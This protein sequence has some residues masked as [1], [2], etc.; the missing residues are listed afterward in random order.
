MANKIVNSQI[1]NLL[2]LQMYSRK[3]MTLAEN[4]FQ[5]KNLPK[6]INTAYMNKTLIN[7]GSIAFF[8]EDALESVIALPFTTY[9]T[10]DIYGEP[11]Q[12][13]VFRC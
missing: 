4:V 11:K 13:Q 5:F 9:G 3:F 6:D 2:T 7:K 8:Y 1:N 10:L 12:I